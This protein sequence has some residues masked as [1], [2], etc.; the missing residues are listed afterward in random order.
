MANTYILISSNVL[1]SSAASVTF[2][3]IPATYTDLLLRT[4]V[5]TDTT[6]TFEDIEMTWN[7]I[8]TTGYYSQT[9]INGDGT[10]TSNQ[11]V[12]SGISKWQYANIP[13][14]SVTSNTFATQEIYIPNYAGTAIKPASVFTVTENNSTSSGFWQTRANAL[15]GNFTSAISSITL[16]PPTGRNFISG[17]SFYLYGIKNS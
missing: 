5:R 7:G 9:W 4:S 3:A 2:S 14:T 10:A 12:R 17:S 16:K 6:G 8:E 13:G 11:Q 1:G 15:L